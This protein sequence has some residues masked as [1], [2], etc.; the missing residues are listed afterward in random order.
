MKKTILI[1]GAAGFIGG[2]LF[3][4]FNDY[5]NVVGIDIVNPSNN[6]QSGTFLKLDIT[7]SQDVRALLAKYDIDFIV[8]SAAAKDLRFC[9]VNRDN[10]Y[11]L[12]FLSTMNLYELSKNKDSKFI[13]ISSD[14]VFD[15]KKGN[16][17]EHSPKHPINH[18]G[19]LKDLCEERLTKDSRVAI[20]R[21]AMVFGNVPPSQKEMFERIAL[22]DKLV[23]QGYVLEHIKRRLINGKKMKLPIDEFCN[24]TSTALIYKQISTIIEKDLSGILHCC[25]GEKIGKYDLGL[26]ITSMYG[27]NNSLIDFYRSED[28]LRP[29]DVSL[30]FSKTQEKMGWSFPDLEDMIN[31]I[32]LEVA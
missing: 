13:F 6:N 22:E 12:N 11:N 3:K 1:T 24:P 15:G 17:A 20:C 23:V 21:T 2:Y 18:Y 4:K 25:G 14:Q 7:D 19:T 29:K 16:Y 5:Y 32:D 26:K 10:S 8:H 30:D 27:L 9:E 28:P 31:E